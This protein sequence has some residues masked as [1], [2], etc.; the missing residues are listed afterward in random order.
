[1]AGDVKDKSKELYDKAAPKAKE[2]FAGVK[3]KGAALADKAKGKFAEFKAKK[4]AKSEEGA[5]A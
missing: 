4:E 5:E 2:A 3:E 1:M